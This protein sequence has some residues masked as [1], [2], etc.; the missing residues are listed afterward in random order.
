MFRGE[1]FEDAALRK[2]RDETGSGAKAKAVGIVGVWCE[3]CFCTYMFIG[4]HSD[5]YLLWLR[6][7]IAWQRMI[8]RILIHFL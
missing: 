7:C 6:I 2:I 3:G 8:T 4:G 5:M 1:T